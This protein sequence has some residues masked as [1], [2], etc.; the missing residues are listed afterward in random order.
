MNAFVL[1]KC[2]VFV[3]VVVVA[4][5][6]PLNLTFLIMQLFNLAVW[7]WFFC[8]FSS[9]LCCG[10]DPST[11]VSS[12]VLINVSDEYVSYLLLFLRQG[13]IILI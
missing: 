4:V 10:R 9:K 3:V 8:F 12:L 11:R 1:V 13:L 7:F 6:S 2:V 5:V